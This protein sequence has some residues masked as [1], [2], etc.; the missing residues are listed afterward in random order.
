[1]NINV[2]K[3]AY[4]GIALDGSDHHIT[5]Y[6]IGRF[7]TEKKKEIILSYASILDIKVSGVFKEMG[8]YKNENVGLKVSDWTK[9]LDDYFKDNIPH[10]TIATMNNG[11][12]VNTYKAFTEEG[13]YFPMPPINWTGT[14]KLFD[15]NNN[16]IE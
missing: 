13:E 15:Y 12:A 6:Y 4:I 2:N 9:E 10:T 5:L 16:I 3:V 1:M 14:V 11:K 7:S 8:Y